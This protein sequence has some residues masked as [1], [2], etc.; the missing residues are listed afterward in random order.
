MI[1]GFSN[2]KTEEYDNAFLGEGRE[3]RDNGARARFKETR[4]HPKGTTNNKKGHPPCGI[5]F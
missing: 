1:S 2:R 5:V 4:E 3:F